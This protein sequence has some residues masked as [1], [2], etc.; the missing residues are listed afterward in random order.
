[1]PANKAT[2]RGNG[3]GKGVG[4]GGK[5][6]GEGNHG[7]GPGRPPAD[8]AKLIAARREERIAALKEHLLTLAV[9][10][11]RE[12]TQ[13][14]ATVAFLNREEGTPVQRQEIS[15]GAAPLKIER[16]IIDPAKRED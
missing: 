14:S 5:D 8:V 3:V 10:A 15:G 16:V 1:M 9:T 2:R 7:P 6:K 11:E 12:E 13:L 4:W